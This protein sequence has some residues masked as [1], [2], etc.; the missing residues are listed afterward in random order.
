MTGIAERL[1]LFRLRNSG[2][3]KKKKN[4][5]AENVRNSRRSIQAKLFGTYAV[6]GLLTLIACLVSWN[7]FRTVERT[8]SNVAER[9]IQGMTTAFDLAAQANQITNTLRVLSAVKTH[10]ERQKLGEQLNAS[11]ETLNRLTNAVRA[12]MSEEEAARTLEIVAMLHDQTAS[13]D[14]SVAAMIDAKNARI[15][16]IE[17]IRVLHDNILSQTQ[18]FIQQANDG[19]FENMELLYDND[20]SSVNKLQDE[21]TILQGAMDI[22]AYTNLAAG[23]LAEAAGTGEKEEVK[24]LSERFFQATRSITDGSGM[25]YQFI[26]SRDPK[27][28][29]NYETLNKNVE[30][31]ILSGYSDNDMFD[32]HIAELDQITRMGNSLNQA[33][34]I[35]EELTT[36][37]NSQVANR[38]KAVDAG[39]DE[40]SS[41]ISNSVTTLIIL[42][43]S[44]IAAVAFIAWFYVGRSVTTPLKSMVSAMRSLADGDLSV[45][46]PAQNRKD[47]IGQMSGAV[48]IFKENAVEMDRA[49]K[50]RD[51][52]RE[53]AAQEKR[54]AMQKLADDFQQSVGRIVEAVSQNATTMMGTAEQMSGSATRAHEQS[55]LVANSSQNAN[56][57]VET[58][59]TACEQLSASI[60]EISQQTANSNAIAQSAVQRADSTNE[61]VQTLAEA[62]SRISDVVDLI[63]DI[64][65]QT[66]L[67]ALNATIEA[68]RA[69]D[70]GK[71]FAVVAT[72][73]K[74]L[75]D[76]TAKA[77]DEISAQIESMQGVTS[78]AVEAI[79]HIRATVG[80]ISEAVTSVAS[81]V[82][83]QSA[84]TEEI[85]R[86]TQEAAEATRSVSGSIEYVRKANNEAG[87][88]ATAVVNAA[89]ELDKQSVQLRSEVDRFLNEIR[90]A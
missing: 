16:E 59:A 78:N 11:Q 35:A 31:L 64:A 84:A 40:V 17:Q 24:R 67:L 63:H 58:V 85:S 4:S 19:V 15:R 77:T 44:T 14:K 26:L 54:E 48:Q 37:V 3:N 27:W 80:E 76:Q 20:T 70:A 69:G 75:A 28:T 83:E 21:M 87:D 88:A 74:N 71:G 33:Q 34:A 6:V 50:E 30:Q 2:P 65:N 32:K 22:N 25:L 12:Q 38:R 89:S 39:V 51:E 46:I 56:S 13:L 5:S 9:D 60:N 79:G 90:A 1:N 61:T 81:A 53:K 41:S 68:A 29:E 73:V 45:S 72:E 43:I 36:I 49:K 86:N 57:N 66:N 23:L 47:E 62:A 8:F 55:D 82:E 7:S 10:A 18:F 42:A 52:M